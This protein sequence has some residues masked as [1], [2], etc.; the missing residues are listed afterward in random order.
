M[1]KYLLSNCMS[2]FSDYP[3][4]VKCSLMIILSS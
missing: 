2:I 1:N 3:A 4:F